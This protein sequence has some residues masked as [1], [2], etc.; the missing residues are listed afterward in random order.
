MLKNVKSSYFSII[1]FS[2]VNEKQKLKLVTYNKSLQKQ[3][4]I[5]I[6]IC[7]SKENI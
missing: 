7:I 3:I 4:N 1:V 2:Y 6:I 5:S